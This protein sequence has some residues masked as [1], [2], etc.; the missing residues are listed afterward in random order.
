MWASTHRYVEV[1][2][3][4]VKGHCGGVEACRLHGDG[5]GEQEKDDEG[6]GH[7]ADEH[8]QEHEELPVGK[9]APG[10]SSAEV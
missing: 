6:G 9:Q 5:P 4:I 8:C 10:S 2:I 1:D 7:K 3:S